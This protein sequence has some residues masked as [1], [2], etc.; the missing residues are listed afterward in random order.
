MERCPVFRTS[1]S[2]NQPPSPICPR[3][4]LFSVNRNHSTPHSKA[5][6][7]PHPQTREI[8]ASLDCNNCLGAIRL[9]FVLESEW[10]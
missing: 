1:Y 4:G 9:Y 7:L 3:Q 6:C 5:H 10:T 2:A 8:Q